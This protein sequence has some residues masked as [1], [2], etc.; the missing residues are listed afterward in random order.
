MRLDQP[1]LGALYYRRNFRR[2]DHQIFFLIHTCIARSTMMDFEFDH[3]D[4]A[5]FA[6]EEH[7]AIA[8]AVT[9]MLVFYV[10]VAVYAMLRPVMKYI[11]QF[12]YVL[13]LF[14]YIFLV[15]TITKNYHRLV[16]VYYGIRDPFDVQFIPTV[17][18]IFRGRSL[19]V[20]EITAPCLK[21]VTY[22]ACLQDETQPVS[23][24]APTYE[25]IK[26]AVLG[27]IPVYGMRYT[28]GTQDVTHIASHVIVPEPDIDHIRMC[29][30]VRVV[31]DDKNDEL[32]Y[33]ESPI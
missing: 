33:L 18:R 22:Y 1:R 13:S 4:T 19:V 32:V 5:L 7:T 15:H 31:M 8:N 29:D 21:E 2:F 6:I 26:E 30:I 24:L 23:T 17:R 20:F 27:W 9:A 10:L 28:L 16:A 25:E 12:A 11:G 14:V 3:D